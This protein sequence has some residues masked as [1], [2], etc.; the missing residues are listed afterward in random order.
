[1]RVSY[2]FLPDDWTATQLINN[3]MT[4][5]QII[6]LSSR[7]IYIYRRGEPGFIEK[8]NSQRTDYCWRLLAS[9]KLI[10]LN[11]KNCKNGESETTYL[12]S[13]AVTITLKSDIPDKIILVEPTSGTT[14]PLDVPKAETPN[15]TPPKS[16][17]LNQND[18][19]WID[20]S[21][22]DASKVDTVEANQLKLKWR[23][24]PLAKKGESIKKG[25]PVKK[26]QVEITRDLTVKLGN[27]DLTVLD[28]DGKP[29]GG[30][31]LNIS[32]SQNCNDNGGKQ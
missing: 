19:V 7:S 16:I 2:P 13:N 1:M 29:I 21:V 20:V 22:D 28:K 24:P 3:P 8:P 27:V 31:R 6:R 32:C 4:D 5:F 12:S 23:I 25:E 26:I 10:S 18:S 9:D 11:T 17:A 15:V 14:Y 30:T